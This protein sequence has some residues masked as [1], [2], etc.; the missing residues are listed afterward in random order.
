MA[1]CLRFDT[2]NGVK[3][4]KTMARLKPVGSGWMEA[5]LRA[6]NYQTPGGG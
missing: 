1:G 6:L 4:S 5:W 3:A 2:Q